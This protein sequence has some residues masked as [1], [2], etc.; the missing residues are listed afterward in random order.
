MTPRVNASCIGDCNDDELVVVPE[1]VTGVNIALGRAD[2]DAC[3]AFAC[4]GA[5]VDVYVNCGV[6][7]VRNALEG[8][9]T[10]VP[11]PTST[12]RAT[13]TPPPT[14]TVVYDLIEGSMMLASSATPSSLPIVEPLSGSL[15][16]TV[17]CGNPLECIAVRGPNV[18]FAMTIISIAFESTHFTFVGSGSIEALS[19]Y[20]QVAYAGARL[21]NAGEE[22]AAAG[23]GAIDYPGDFPPRFNDLE[24]CGGDASYVVSCDAIRRGVEGGYILTLVAVPRQ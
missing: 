19:F 9:P 4:N 8:C 2:V 6:A 24:V 11:S 22:F 12:P 17:D 1:I 13:S 20:P 15:L 14:V 18:L 3:A 5:D 21:L 7:A 16:A 23:Q 10:L